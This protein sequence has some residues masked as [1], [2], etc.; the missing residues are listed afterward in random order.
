M[1]TA[2][3]C[4]AV[5]QHRLVSKD[6]PQPRT[7]PTRASAGVDGPPTGPRRGRGRRPSAVVRTEILAAADQL[8]RSRGMAGFTIEGVAALAGASKMTIYKWWPSRGVLALEAY[9]A[10]VD[11]VLGVP[12]TGD[13][14][15]DLTTQ[16]TT[17]VRMLRNT[18]AG[19]VSAEL[20]G[21]AQT[22]PKLADAFRRIYLRPRRDVGTAALRAAQARGQVRADVDLEVIS[23]QLWGACIYRLMMGHQPLSDEFARD[24]VLNLLAGIAGPGDQRSHG[25]RAG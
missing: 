3:V 13:I 20:V 21:G 17:L 12:D 11:D 18:T 24:L 1:T 15:R 8:L 2:A 10:G 14:E 22:D 9:A 6:P 16:L 5:W 23:D 25:R 7:G 19:R 4:G